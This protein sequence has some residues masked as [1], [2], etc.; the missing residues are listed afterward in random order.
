MNILNKNDYSIDYLINTD[1]SL[2]YIIENL[3]EEIIYLNTH[4]GYWDIDNDQKGDFI[5]I[6]TGEYWTNETEE[7]YQFEINNQMI[8]EGVVGNKSFI[9]FTPKLIEFYY[10]EN[11]FPNSLIYMATCFASFDKSMANA[12]LNSGASVYL[13]WK[14]DTMSWI[15]SYTSV[16]TFNML[17]KKIPVK[18]ICFAIRYGGFF[19]FFLNSKLVYYGDGNF[20]MV[21]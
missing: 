19:N 14:R 8:V 4:G 15:N 3:N 10:Q 17:S 21:E 6:S 7:K 1:V 16:R 2:Q 12:F 18:Y 20:K 13:G 5:V 11:D 9:T